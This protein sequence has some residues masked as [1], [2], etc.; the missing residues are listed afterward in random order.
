MGIL[1]RMKF[2]TW[3]DFFGFLTQILYDISPILY[4][5]LLKLNKFDKQSISFISLFGL[6]INALIYFFLNVFNGNN[7]KGIVPRDY[8]NLV[9]TYLG[10]IYLALYFHYIYYKTSIKKLIIIYISIILLSG[11]IVVI[12]WLAKISDYNDTFLHILDW[13]GVFF[14]ILEY[15]PIGFNL[16]YFIK[17][18]TSEEIMIISAFFGLINTLIWISWAIYTTINDSQKYHSITANFIGI[19]LLI[20]QFII[21]CKFKK[22]KIESISAIDEVN[23]DKIRD[24]ENRD[25]TENKDDNNSED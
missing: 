20:S 22:I 7:N 11:L 25:D 12:E 8:C 10:F 5:M 3:F 13:I 23:Y 19:I 16:I 21:V 18:K 24:S 9:G 4:I 14:N 6:Y 17:N 1:E 2:D 15:F